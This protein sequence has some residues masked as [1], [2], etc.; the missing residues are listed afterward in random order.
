MAGHLADHDVAEL[1]DGGDAAT[2]AERDGLRALIDAAARD[3][4]VLRLQRARDVVD[5]QVLRR[6]AARR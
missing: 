6:A 2:R 1:V 4:D 3:F 5:G